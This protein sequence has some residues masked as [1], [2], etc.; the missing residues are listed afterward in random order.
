MTENLKRFLEN[1]SENEELAKKINTMTKD[2][3]LALA[4][5]LGI[6]LTDADLEMPAGD[7]SADE[8]A[9]VAGGGDCFCAIG[10]GGTGDENDKP[11]GC[12]ASG[13]GTSYELYPGSDERAGRCLCILG[14][15]GEDL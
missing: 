7:L 11:C 13:G 15:W 6:E 1:V 3:L 5:E 8:L 12:V 4:K 14:G 9:A 10:G 2:D